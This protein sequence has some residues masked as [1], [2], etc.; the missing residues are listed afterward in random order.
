MIWSILTEV[1]FSEVENFI[2]SVGKED[3]NV[4]MRA[5][6]KAVDKIVQDM[7]TDV[8]GMRDVSFSFN[9]KFYF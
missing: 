1:D 5:L 8:T 4:D 6:E 9:F 3:G 7:K 2:K